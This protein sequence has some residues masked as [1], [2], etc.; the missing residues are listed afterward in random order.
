MKILKNANAFTGLEAAIV[1][2]AFVVVAAVFSYVVLGAGFFTTQ[3]SQEVVHT[4]VEQASSSMEIIGVV[5]GYGNDK[6]GTAAGLKYVVFTVGN[7]AGGAPIDMEK[8]IVTYISEDEKAVNTFDTEKSIKLSDFTPIKP[9]EA[10]TTK[11]NE[12]NDGK[13]VILNILNDNGKKNYLLEPG[14][15]FILAIPLGISDPGVNRKFSLTLQP[16]V[17]AVFSIHK[18]APSFIDRVNILNK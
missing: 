17:G 8:M 10:E 14:E 11:P 7:T 16:A 13:W 6:S 1:L 15:Q 3:K 2:I 4:G 12:G 5:F 9:E 18:T